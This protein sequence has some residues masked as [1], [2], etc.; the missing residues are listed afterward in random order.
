MEPAASI[1]FALSVA[2]T[3]DTKHELCKDASVFQGG[4][5]CPSRSIAK[6]VN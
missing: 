6:S 5:S 2:W 4:A 1:F 3:T